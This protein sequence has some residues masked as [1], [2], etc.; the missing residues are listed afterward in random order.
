MMKNWILIAVLIP[1]VLMGQV[2][3][4]GYF[5]SEFDNMS[6]SDQ[7]YNYGYNKLRVDIENSVIDGVTFGANVNIQRYYG[8]TK[9]NLLDFLPEDIWKPIFQPLGITEFPFAVSDTLYLDNAFLRMHFDFGDLTV[10][11]QQI[12]LG[13]GYAWNPLD[14]FNT[15]LLLDPTY[16]QTGINGIR[17]EISVADRGMLDIIL[18]PGSDWENTIKMVTGKWGL[19]RFD[20]LGTIGC[21]NWERTSINL[22]SF[23]T[24]KISEERL[25]A[26][27]GLVGEISGI[28]VWAE[29]AYN[30]LKESDDFVEVLIGCDYTFENGFYLLGEIYHNGN[31]PGDFSDLGWDNYMQYLNGETHSLLNDYAFLTWLYPLTDFVSIGMINFANLSDNSAAFNPQL[32]WNVFEDVTLGLLVGYYIGDEDSEFGLQDWAGRLRVRAYF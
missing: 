11:K 1:A 9:W 19:G 6:V 10:G 25:L 5:E 12:S 24:E 4:F 7:N 16:E 21:Y 15:K 26:G 32:E 13:V 17:L 29:G 2:N 28:G 23:S 31:A 22:Q 20:L 8:S 27:G 14:I 30:Q 18:S 3:L